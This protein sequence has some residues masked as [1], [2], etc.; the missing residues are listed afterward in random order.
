MFGWDNLTAGKNWCASSLSAMERGGEWK[1]R[2][3]DSSLCWSSVQ[4]EPEPEATWSC[5]WMDASRV[6]SHNLQVRTLILKGWCAGTLEGSQTSYLFMWLH[7]WEPQ[8]LFHSWW[9]VKV[10]CGVKNGEILI[11]TVL[12][13]TIALDSWDFELVLL[14]VRPHPQAQ[15]KSEAVLALTSDI[16]LLDL[17]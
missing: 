17:N 10:Q 4:S 15:I 2:W 8:L 1:E 13:H 7:W 16:W 12:L 3:R 9:A 11:F 14:W 5:Q 6:S